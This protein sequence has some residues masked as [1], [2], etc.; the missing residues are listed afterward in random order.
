MRNT[1]KIISYLFLA[2]SIV[3]TSCA[4]PTQ[5]QIERDKLINEVKDRTLNIPSISSGGVSGTISYITNNNTVL[6][7]SDVRIKVIRQNDIPK[8]N[9]QGKPV[10]TAGKEF[11]DPKKQTQAF[12]EKKNDVLK[13]EILKNKDSYLIAGLRPGDIQVVLTAGSDE[14]QVLAKVEVGKITQIPEIVLGKAS[15]SSSSTVT[16]I[17][18]NIKGRV[19][20]PDGTP[21]ANAKVSDVTQNAVSSSTTTNAQGEFSLQVTSFKKPKNLEANF[22]N[23]TTSITV[24][25]EQV[26]DII[27][28][29]LTNARTVKGKLIDSVNKKPV[30]NI[31]IKSIDSSSSTSTDENGEFTLRGVPTTITTLEI[32]PKTGYI[33]KQEVIQPSD[34][35]TNLTKE[36]EV[37]P[38]GNLVVHLT[39][40]NYPDLLE[41]P[42][43]DSIGNGQSKPATLAVPGISLVPCPG[44]NNS[45]IDYVSN[46]IAFREAIQGT[47][48]IEGTDIVKS[49]TSPPTPII[50]PK[51]ECTVGIDKTRAITVYLRNYEIAV[52]FNDLP[53]GE[54]TISVALNFHETQK[55]I[56]VVVPSNDTITTELIQLRSVNRILAIGDVVGNIFIRDLSGVEI[57]TTAKLKAVALKGEVD[58]RNSTVLSSIF[59]DANSPYVSSATTFDISGASKAQYTLRNVPTGTRTIVVGVVDSSGNLDT[60]YLISSYVSLNVVGNTI[61]K[62]PDANLIKR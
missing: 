41:F 9:A 24:S 38:L 57:P 23:L 56:K 16:K 58:L 27:I 12:L 1:S 32:G 45:R 60:N 10:D 15:S 61:N 8:L 13:N 30:A 31:S 17:G 25:P 53:G 46:G 59:T 26:E 55:G 50:D 28:P 49:F 19:L 7:N 4:P 14:S 47:V 52:P 6:T 39:A 20:R 36:I 51:P 5:D 40:D 34:Q 18:I 48:Q 22:N 2:I 29:L 37:R 21:V 35:E 62:A 33:V 3:S 42:G 44:P 11:T 43:V 54:Y